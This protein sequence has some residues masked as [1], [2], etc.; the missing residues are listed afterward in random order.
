[1]TRAD[2][3]AYLREVEDFAARLAVVERRLGPNDPEV[4]DLQQCVKERRAAVFE[5]LEALAAAEAAGIALP[6][7]PI[8]H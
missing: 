4:R 6:S 2:A 1:M 8:V 3:L 7:P 5:F